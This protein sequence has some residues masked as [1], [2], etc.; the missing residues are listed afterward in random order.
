MSIYIEFKVLAALVFVAVVEPDCRDVNWEDSFDRLGLSE[1]DRMG[2]M[3]VSFCRSPVD[4]SD[5]R[6]GR[7]E[8]ARCCSKPFPWQEGNDYVKENWW[9]SMDTDSTWSLCR[10]GY[11]L[12]GLYRSIGGST[13]SNIEEARCTR[14]LNHPAKYGLCEDVDISD[15][16]EQAKCCSCPDGSFIVGLYRGGCSDLRCLDKLRCCTMTVSPK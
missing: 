13:L 10:D 15:C 6:I 5:D 12:T 9:Q 8:R 14:P 3:L 4:R 11:F 1:C 7:L 2:D 16:F